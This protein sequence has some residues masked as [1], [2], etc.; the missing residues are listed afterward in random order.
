LDPNQIIEQ[1]GGRRPPKFELPHSTEE[2]CISIGASV[3][4]YFLRNDQALGMVAAG[5]RWEVVQADRGERQV[6]KILETLSVLRAEGRFPLYE[7]LYRESIGLARGST[8]IV[9]TPSVNVRW[10]RTA[11][12]LASSGL[13]VV[14]VLVD[15][16]SF[17]GE[18]GATQIVAELEVSGITTLIARRGASWVD[19]FDRPQPRVT[20]W[21]D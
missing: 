17:G 19:V 9:V 1:A 6:L 11:R 4:Q 8:V 21:V 18:T 5:Q 13:R 12:H 10:A 20:K 15:P 2:Y 3:A 7:I 14:A 16:E